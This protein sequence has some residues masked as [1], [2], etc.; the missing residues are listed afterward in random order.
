MKQKFNV[1]LCKVMKQLRKFLYHK[2]GLTNILLQL[3][4]MQ[5]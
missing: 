1:E 5:F 4:L 3:N 2:T